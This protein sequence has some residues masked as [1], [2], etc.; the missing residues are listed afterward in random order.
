M[1]MSMSQTKQFKF[2]QYAAHNLS[3]FSEFDVLNICNL[4]E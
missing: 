4:N 3:L 1:K 2:K